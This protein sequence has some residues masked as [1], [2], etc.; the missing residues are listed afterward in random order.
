[1]GAV[2]AA[3]SQTPSTAVLQR[4]AVQAGLGVVVKTILGVHIQVIYERVGTS[5]VYSVGR[6]DSIV[7]R[8]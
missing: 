3:V 7:T 1:M 8:S 2:H 6:A 5:K 4:R